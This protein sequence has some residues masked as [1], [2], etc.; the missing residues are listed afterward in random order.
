MRSSTT[1]PVR[2]TGQE[3]DWSILVSLCS[4][5]HRRMFAVGQKIGLF[6][7]LNDLLL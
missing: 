6:V 5:A 4:T 3:C 7:E 2:C 1:F